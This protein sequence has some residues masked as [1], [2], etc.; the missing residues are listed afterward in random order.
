MSKRYIVIV[1]ALLA[2]ASLVPYW[3][4][5]SS[6]FVSID[7]HVYVLENSHILDGLTMNGVAWAFTSGY[8]ANWHPLTWLSHMLDVQLFGLNPRWH[9]VTNLLLHMANTMLLFFVLRRMTKAPW[10]SA[11]VAALFALH[12]LHVESV[13]WVAERKDVLSTFFWMLTMGA[14]CHYAER[15]SLSRYAP[16][17]VCFALGLMAKPMLVTLPFV[18]LLLDYWPLGQ[19]GREGAPTK[20]P[21]EA[22]RPAASLKGKRKPGKKKA[23]VKVPAAAEPAASG[24]GPVSISLLLWEKIPLLVLAALSCI[25]TY[26][27]Q[28]EGGAIRS[29]RNYPLDLR[30][31]NAFVSY[32]TYIGKMIVPHDL[33]V[34][35]P[36]LPLSSWQVLGAALLIIAVTFAAVREARRHPYLTVGWLWYA[37]TLVPVIGLVQVGE[38]ALADRYTYVPMIGLFILIA[39]GVPELLGTWRHRNKVLAAASALTLV[40]LFVATWTQTGYWRDDFTLFDHAI[41]VTQDNSVAYYARGYAYEGVGDYRRAIADYDRAIAINARYVLAYNNRGTA[42]ASLGDL[43]QAIADYDGALRIDPKDAEAYTNRGNAHNALGNY[44]QAI[45]DYDRAM[46]INPELAA[47]CYNRGNVY[48]TLGNYGQ[49]IADYDRAIAIN[50]RLAQAYRNRGVSY[51]RLGNK[52][53]A[54]EDVREAAMLGDKAARDLLRSQE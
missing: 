38:Q 44:A 43:K 1:C 37:G 26:I 41:D 33:A 25:V 34:F 50:P 47:P 14:Y 40:G 18:L 28:Q 48:K 6:G 11:F 16:V 19:L 9:H 36:Y 4:A 39:W 10:Q 42:Y 2:A 53:L 23:P 22:G 46:A 20:A 21:I 35:Y 15:R 12:P 8:A 31:E 54:Y 17:L 29:F 52:K 45:A 49:A 24:R 51:Y 30:V 5:N 7:D 3:Q 32:V 13:A 27:V